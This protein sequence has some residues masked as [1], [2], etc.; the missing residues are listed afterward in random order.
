MQEHPVPVHSTCINRGTT[1]T[2]NPSPEGMESVRGA[3]SDL[4]PGIWALRLLA[5]AW[6]SLPGTSRD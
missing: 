5:A 2:K 4:K 3:F 6:K 1:C